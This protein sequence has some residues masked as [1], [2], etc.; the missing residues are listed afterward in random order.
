MVGGI[1]QREAEGRT[2]GD[3]TFHVRCGSGGIKQ[4]EEGAVGRIPQ[5]PSQWYDLGRYPASCLSGMPLLRSW[6][7]AF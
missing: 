5:P 1:L 6:T 3:G 2:G 7:L 4:G